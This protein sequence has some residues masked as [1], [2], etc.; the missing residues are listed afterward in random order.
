MPPSPPKKP[1]RI[2]EQAATSSPMPSEII[3]KA[4]PARLVET[5]PKMTAKNRP[6]RPP[7]SGSSGSGIGSLPAPMTF[8]ACAVMKPPRP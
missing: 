4:V 8:S 7:T 6:A 5:Q 3:A 2:S 1:R